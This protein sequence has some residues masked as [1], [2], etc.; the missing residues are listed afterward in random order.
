[1]I[2]HIVACSENNVIGVNG[3]LPWHLSE[4]LKRFKRLTSNHV[5]IMGRKTHESIG[6]PL[7][8]RVNVIITRQLNYDAKG[9]LVAASL[10][11][12]LKVSEVN[13]DE[14]FII[15]GG[16]IYKQSID[17]VDTIYMTRV[18]G[19]IK[20]DAYYPDIPSD[21]E[22]VSKAELVGYSFSIYR[23]RDVKET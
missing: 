8:N 4:D 11:D 23:R 1:M 18:Y 13:D 20:G 5:I 21:F 14:I 10:E 17:I 19:E 6:K 7:P 22:E 3:E 9:C 15:G 12:A 2:S 16:E